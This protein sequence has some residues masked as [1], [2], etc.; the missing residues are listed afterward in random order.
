MAY[1]GLAMPMVAKLTEPANAY[2][3]AFT[4]GKAIEIHVSPQ[5]AEGN[6]YGD[7]AK[8]EFD[9]EFQ[10]ADV[11]LGT[12]SLPLKAHEIMF[13]RTVTESKVAFNANDEAGYVGLGFY[14][15]EKVDGARKY[16]A[17]WLYKVKFSDGEEV[18][19][20]K[21]NTIEYQTP[22]ITG[23][24]LALDDGSWKDFETF[25]TK[26]AAIEWLNKK[27]GKTVA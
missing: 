19:K 7:D 9:K 5:Y 13:G 8:S 14:V 26:S 18:Y 2:S 25:D 3:E 22:S 27:A 20:T 1:I 24:A 21:G 6:L 11:T 15:T 10:Y 17:S 16:S 4:C 12:T 23:Q